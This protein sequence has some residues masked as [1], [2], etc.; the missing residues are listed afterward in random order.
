MRVS[1]TS[2]GVQVE[3]ETVI[4]VQERQVIR[5]TIIREIV[6]TPKKERVAPAMAQPTISPADQQLMDVLGPIFLVLIIGLVT[7]LPLSPGLSR[8]S[9]SPY[10][11]TYGNRY[12]TTT[13][14]AYP[15]NGQTTYYY[16]G[17]IRR[18]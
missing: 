1:N 16:K 5:E 15:S 8:G 11:Q 18:P 12:N 6:V 3:E 4:P 7:L 14:T 13:G 2:F 17:Y 9:N 10:D